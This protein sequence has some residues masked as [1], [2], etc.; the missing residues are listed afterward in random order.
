MKVSQVLNH[1]RHLYRQGSEL[2]D[3]LCSTSSCGMASLLRVRWIST[4]VGGF[5]TVQGALNKRQLQTYGPRGW[6]N[7]EGKARSGKVLIRVQKIVFQFFPIR[8]LPNRGA[9]AR[10]ADV[11]NSTAIQGDLNPFL[12][13]LSEMVMHC[14]LILYQI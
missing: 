5:L 8:R 12:Q 4:D 10:N 3:S 2:K 9:W 1:L 6:E 11:Y 7:E 13:Q 14:V